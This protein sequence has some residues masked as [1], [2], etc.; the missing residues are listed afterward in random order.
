M[1][2]R[3]THLPNSK[4]SF[5]DS[6]QHILYWLSGKFGYI[7]THIHTTTL[8]F[9][10]APSHFTS[11]T[12]VKPLKLRLKPMETHL[13]NI[14][15]KLLNTNHNNEQLKEKPF[16]WLFKHLTIYTWCSWTALLSPSP[17]CICS[18]I[19]AFILAI[20]SCI[21]RSWKSSTEESC[22]LVSPQNMILRCHHIINFLY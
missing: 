8:M 9:S 18:C 22:G 5:R 19:W 3:I 4:D 16:Q 20:I 15:P 7:D 21:R 10:S 2:L 14:F 12:A 11:Q 13:V 17:L 1:S 6:C